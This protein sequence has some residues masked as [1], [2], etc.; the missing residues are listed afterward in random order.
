MRTLILSELL[1]RKQLVYVP[2]LPNRIRLSLSPDFNQSLVAL[3]LRMAY[4]H[5]SWAN[6]VRYTLGALVKL[7]FT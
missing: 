4:E 1:N 3:R 7:M 6:N 5:L 2:Y